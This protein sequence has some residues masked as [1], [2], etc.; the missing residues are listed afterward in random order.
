MA[1]LLQKFI[2]SDGNATDEE[3]TALL[4]TFDDGQVNIQEQ[5]VVLEKVSDLANSPKTAP[6]LADEVEDL[7]KIK[8]FIQETSLGLE[9]DLRENAVAAAKNLISIFQRKYF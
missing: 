3:K 2:A 6:N 8:L 7:K 5:L 4:K 1:P 9:E